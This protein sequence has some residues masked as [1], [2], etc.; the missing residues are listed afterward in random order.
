MAKEESRLGEKLQ[1]VHHLKNLG[2]SVEETGG[3]T[4]EISQRVSAAWGNWKRCMYI[5][6]PDMDIQ[7]YTV[8]MKK[9]VYSV[10]ISSPIGRGR[11]LNT[12]P[13][14]S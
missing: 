4:T 2:S 13:L 5:Y 6:S 12:G 8:T 11:A 1:R 10:K 9:I 14:K 3:M 7:K